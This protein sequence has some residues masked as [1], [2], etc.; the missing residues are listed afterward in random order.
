MQ[1]YHTP[2][3]LGIVDYTVKN[4]FRPDADTIHLLNPV[5]LEL[6]KEIKPK[7]GKLEVWM[8]GN[9][10][11]FN[12]TLKA[13][14][15]G[16]PY[17]TIRLEGVDAPEEHYRAMPFTIK[18]G[19]KKITYPL[20]KNKKQGERSQPMWKPGTDFVLGVLEKAKYA[21][22]ELD[23][24]VIDSH[25][26]VLGYVYSSDSQGR[27]KTFVTLEL[28]KRGLAF[29]F[30]FESAKDYIETF[31]RAAMNARKNRYGVWKHYK[32]K[33]LTYNETY[34]SPKHHTDLEPKEQASAALNFPMVF[35]RIVDS[36]QLKGLSL[37]EALQ[38]YDTIDYETGKMVTGDKYDHI[39]IDRRIWAP[40]SYK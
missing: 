9:N 28:L 16:T 39:P 17:V 11:P 13:L 26:R 27:K 37:K 3:L 21:L 23:S 32:E 33:P 35:R 38:K 29:P 20:D 34:P 22:I 15:D 19:Q 7:N 2:H 30:I 14:K 1:I 12:I 4:R 40:H 25:N 8:P 5:L 36:Y 18:K 24:E 6:G 31:L 10:H